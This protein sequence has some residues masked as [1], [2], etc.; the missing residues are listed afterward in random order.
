MLFSCPAADASQI[1]QSSN[2]EPLLIVTPTILGGVLGL[3]VII[4]TI[5]ITVMVLVTKN[6][7][8]EASQSTQPLPPEFRNEVD[9]M[10][11]WTLK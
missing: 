1:L 6:R 7:D 2:D 4:I 5:L 3:S 8:S 10:E 11:P 9:R